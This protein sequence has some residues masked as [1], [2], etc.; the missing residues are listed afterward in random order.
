MAAYIILSKFSPGAFRTPDEF[1][2]ASNALT[3]KLKRECPGV[4]W[5]ASYATLGH[6]DV[7]DFVEADDPADVNRAAM[8]IHT[9]AH[10]TTE[11]MMATPWREYLA[12][13]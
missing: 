13:M 7:L 4:H 8:L 12:R 5:K 2:E 10:A 11:T 1:R 3:E 9:D 6:Y